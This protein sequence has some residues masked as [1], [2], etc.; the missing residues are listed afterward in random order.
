M[1]VLAPV[2]ETRHG[3]ALVS[4]R[5]HGDS[6]MVS[7][8]TSP[9]ATPSSLAA[10]SHPFDELTEALLRRRQSAKW[11]VFSEDV[12]PAWV[13]EMDYPLAAP[14][15]A[16][17]AAAL[18]A[19]DAGY[20][21]PRG[22][23]AATA[24]WAE[25]SWGWKIAPGDVYVIADVVTGI[26]EIL[27]VSTAPGDRVVIEPPVYHPFAAT[28]ERFGR[29]VEPAPIALA[30]GAYHPDLDAIERAYAGGARAH[31]L[32]SPHNPS[33]LVYSR[34]ALARIAELAERYHVLI[35]SDEIHAPLT[36][37]G[38]THHPFPT[39]SA[40]AADCS[41]VMTSASKAWNIAGLKAAV[42]IAPG[43][44]GRAE[45]AKLPEDTPYHAGHLG[46]LATRAAFTEG[47]QWLASVRAIL[48]RNR[49]LLGSLLAE[50]LPEVRW[51]PQRAGYLCW[52]DC[53]DLGL[54]DDPARAFTRHGKV[55]LSSGPMF[56][57]QGK[58]FA[59]LNIATSR[60]LL[61]EAVRRMAAAVKAVREGR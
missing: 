28:I 53:R 61:E 29:V 44:R 4:G 6:R 55:A 56:G 45:L 41:I 60:G 2:S 39:V 33:G 38:A 26:G 16:A 14:I 58:G 31:I 52:L 54:G 51:I 18:D 1:R 3:R 5:A 12:L 40:A 49:A 17:L 48:E 7:A 47:Q 27:R 19:E 37:A 43:A 59:R 20:A 13:A 11:K 36:L 46:V 15:R 23:G 50:H 57:A 35:V 24:P 22:L 9:P 8:V 34:E 42:M 21:D 30:D 32:C 10:Q 25:A